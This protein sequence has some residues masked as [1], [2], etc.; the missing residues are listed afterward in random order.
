MIL[1]VYLMCVYVYTIYNDK[2]GGVCVCVRERERERE[3]ER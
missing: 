1:F 2:L 3:R